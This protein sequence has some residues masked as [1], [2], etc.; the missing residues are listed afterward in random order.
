MGK[1]A[2]NDEPAYEQLPEDAIDLKTASKIL[3][4]G[5]GAV[6][7]MIHDGRLRAW[8]VAGARYRA[9]EADVRALV[10]PVKA[11]PRARTPAQMAAGDK[12]ARERLRASGMNLDPP[13][14]PEEVPE[15]FISV[16]DAASILRCAGDVVHGMVKAGRLQSRKLRRVGRTQVFVVEAEVRA[17][18][19]V[20]TGKPGSRRFRT[21][22]EIEA[23]EG[24]KATLREGA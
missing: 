9:S 21:P 13:Q 23:R 4:V 22:M 20:G 15:G 5:R 10:E 1:Q 18:V 8:K 14:P 24:K 6:Q 19:P 3:T 12:A 11:P 2:S 17:L 16:S 7:R